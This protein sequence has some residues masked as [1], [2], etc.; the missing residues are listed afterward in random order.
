[1]AQVEQ[2][3]KGK[4]DNPAIRNF[5]PK[6]NNDIAGLKID[7]RKDIMENFFV[8]FMRQYKKKPWI[9]SDELA[10]LLPELDRYQIS[11]EQLYQEKLLDQLV[12]GRILNKMVPLVIQV[13]GQDVE[14]QG[15][16]QI[17]KNALGE[18]EVRVYAKR[19]EPNLKEYFGHKFTDAQVEHIKRTGT[20][21][22]IIQAQ[23]PN[24]E[25]KVPVLLKLDKDTNIFHAQ[26]V[27]D[28]KIQDQ[29]F[30]ATISD[31]QKKELVEGGTIKL[32]NM[33]SYK[34]GKKFYGNVQYDPQNKS[35]EL[36][37]TERQKQEQFL[38]KTIGGKALT[39]EQ[40]QDFSQGK[41]ILITD[42][43]SPNGGT[44]NTYVTKNLA[45]QKW[46]FVNVATNAKL[47][48]KYALYKA[49]TETYL[50][51]N[52]L[53]TQQQNEIN[54]GRMIA[55]DG[56]VDKMKQPFTAY[57][58]KHSDGTLE[59]ASFKSS[60]INVEQGKAIPEESA[61][62][63]AS[64]V[65][66]KQEVAEGRAK[67]VVEDPTK[68]A[69]PE[70]LLKHLENN[71]LTVQQQHDLDAGRV[72]IIGGMV[73][74]MGQPFT[75]HIIKSFETNTLKYLSVESQQQTI[76]VP[77]STS[78]KAT[79]N[80]GYVSEISKEI[81]KSMEQKQPNVPTIN[82]EKQAEK[83]KITKKKPKIRR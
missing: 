10:K 5:V 25:D 8:N 58:V 41:T 39:P 61:K 60:T 27:A 53:S 73:D 2:E 42:V 80:S 77:I 50:Q 32:N 35:L 81:K 68:Q 22:E 37:F 71:P 21:G 28:I 29:F 1:M 54:A 70:D 51:S 64:E 11:V 72:V 24:T 38:P 46:D 15:K 43:K 47:S 17:S 52:P 79:D 23:Y 26:R 6:S 19:Q 56:M 78:T 16:I 69:V 14:T 66:A 59:Y 48:P 49:I 33:V 36:V 12:N 20:P 31:K 57:V 63:A 83:H 82:K 4:E 44:Y 55:I 40:Q 45:T 62:Q 34:T 67:Q 13:D 3:K 76:S 9:T 65:S 18:P 75:A 30:G 7:S 74:K